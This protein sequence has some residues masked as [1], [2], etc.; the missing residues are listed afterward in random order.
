MK[1][2]F[3]QELR[4]GDLVVFPRQ[5]TTLE[6]GTISRITP[7]H[8]HINQSARTSA[9]IVKVPKEIQLMRVLET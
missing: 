6:E 1:D 5:F 2:R 9:D 3:G 7:T 4:I 8:A